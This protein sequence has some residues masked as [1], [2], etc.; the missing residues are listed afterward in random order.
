MPSLERER[1]SRNPQEA[2]GARLRSAR[3]RRGIPVKTLA[4]TTKVAASLFEAL[5]RGDLSRWPKGIY[6]RS[7]FRSYV[8]AVGLPTESTVDEF[9]RLFPDEKP[10]GQK[11]APPAAGEPA[12]DQ[13]PF[14]LTLAPGVRRL[15]LPERLSRTA[16]AD[17]A[18]V[19]AGAAALAWGA[20]LDAPAALAVIVLCYYPQLSRLIRREVKIRLK[21]DRARDRRDPDETSAPLQ[22]DR[23]V[24][25]E[26]SAEAAAVTASAT[27]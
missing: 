24:G 19:L 16:V 23:N 25:P 13:S 5:E 11:D 9:L 20:G 12:Q 3:E 22:P 10:L 27:T 6:K 15:E 18:V 21:T 7:F 14:R 26:H 4:E 1:P 17:A 2:F 8:A